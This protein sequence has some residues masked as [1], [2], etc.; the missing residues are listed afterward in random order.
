MRKNAINYAL[1]SA[2]F[3]PLP[4]LLFP[5]FLPLCFFPHF[6]PIIFRLFSIWQRIHFMLLL[7]CFAI[8]AAV[9]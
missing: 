3:A 1:L 9:A 4:S 7:L 6:S 8:V 2:A 5:L